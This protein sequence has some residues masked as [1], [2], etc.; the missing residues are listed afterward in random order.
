MWPAPQ[1]LG[2]SVR[3]VL[4]GASAGFGC[5]CIS[6][7]PWVEGWNRGQ[8]DGCALCRIRCDLGYLRGEWGAGGFQ[9]LTSGVVPS[10]AGCR[11]YR[12]L[13][14]SRMLRIAE[15]DGQG[16]RACLRQ[17]H[18]PT[19]PEGA[20]KGGSRMQ[21]DPPKLLP[22]GVW[23]AGVNRLDASDLMWAF[24][25]AVP[26]VVIEGH[27]PARPGWHGLPVPVTTG[28]PAPRPRTVR[29]LRF[30]LLLSPAEAIALGTHVDQAD[31]GGLFAWQTSRRPPD[32]L[33]LLDV[34]H[35]ARGQVMRNLAISLVIDLPHSKES[36]VLQSPR[37]EHLETALTRLRTHVMI[38]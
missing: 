24:D 17:A 12:H 10:P 30:D 9:N 4:T 32:F 29:S 18:C 34:G 28:D 27:S 6:R 5:R 7:V 13:V 23:T 31:Q 33:S 26:H 35:R 16:Q 38:E 15:P 2:H 1:Q 37:R 22:N 8:S 36:A 20:R 11:R 21:V 19:V 25:P 14:A 3:I